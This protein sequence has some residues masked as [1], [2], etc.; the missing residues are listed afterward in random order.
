MVLFYYEERE[1]QRVG[2]GLKP[3]PDTDLAVDAFVEDFSQKHTKDQL[4]P[5]IHCNNKTIANERNSSH[6]V[7]NSKC[8]RLKSSF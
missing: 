7:G 3:L 8:I 5:R 2:W 4:V 6:E 1:T